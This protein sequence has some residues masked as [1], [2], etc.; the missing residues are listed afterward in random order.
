MEQHSDLS[1]DQINAI[2][3]S[4]DLDDDQ[5]KKDTQAQ[6]MR[7]ALS[8]RPSGKKGIPTGSIPKY[9]GK[10]HPCAGK[11]NE[12]ISIAKKGVPSIKKGMSKYIFHSDRGVFDNIHE[13]AAAH[14]ETSIGVLKVWA[15]NSKNGFWKELK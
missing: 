9:K 15:L 5:V 13:L 2:L 1:Q 7:D 6:K 4:I 11:P 14:P 10:T 3:N 12:K 8:G